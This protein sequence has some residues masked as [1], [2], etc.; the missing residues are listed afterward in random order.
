MGWAVLMLLAVPYIPHHHHQGMLCTVAD[1]FDD[2]VNE[3]GEE[4]HDMAHH[5][6]DDDA[7]CLRTEHF[8]ISRHSEQ[9]SWIGILLN[10]LIP[11]IAWDNESLLDPVLTESF[12]I[13]R[14][15]V[16]SFYTNCF[17]P[18]AWSLRAPPAWLA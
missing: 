13:R 11:A 4:H 6:G 8:L 5:H 1:M 17:A 12:D 15:D 16:I 3:P 10:S 14:P 9:V 18:G 2:E 7:L